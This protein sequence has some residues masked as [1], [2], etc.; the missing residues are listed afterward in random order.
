MQP[1]D[2]LNDNVLRLGDKPLILLGAG[3]SVEA[4]IPA[5]VE[6]TRVIVSRIGEATRH[7]KIAQALHFVCGALVAYD[8]A[9]GADPYAGLDVERVIAAVE[10]LAE[11][12]GLAVSPFVSAWHPAVDAWDRPVARDGFFDNNLRNAIMERRGSSKAL[13]ANLIDARVG[14][15]PGE[16]YRELQQR[17]IDELRTIVGNPHDV[18]YLQ[19]LVRAARSRGGLWVA[20]LNYDLAIEAACALEGANVYTGIDDWLDE[21][22]WKWGAPADVKLLKLHGSID[23]R[24]DK[25]EGEKGHMPM[26]VVVR[27]D[28][29]VED[30]RPPVVLF[31]QRGKLREEGPFLSLLAEFELALSEASRL[32]AIGYSFRD[33][34]INTVITRWT[35]GDKAT[36]HRSRRSRFP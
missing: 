31:G 6:A 4:G 19:P 11:R 3:A 33:P 16:T 24:W 32:I 1:N 26:P 20:T 12:R 27:T 9:D 22:A 18:E 2:S 14:V 34:H 25:M 10:L 8:S 30:E 29:P 35:R 7:G 5:T 17:M 28:E 13:I 21:R 23:W 36:N 15:G